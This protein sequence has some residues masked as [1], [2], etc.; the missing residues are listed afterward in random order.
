MKHGPASEVTV[1]DRLVWPDGALEALLA[2]GERRREL[3]AYFG[4]EEYAALVPVARRAAARAPD[5][6]RAV[7]LVPGIMGSQLGVPRAAPLPDDLLWIDPVD[8]SH[9]GLLRLGLQNGDVQSCGPVVHSYLRLKL[10]LS[11]EG[12]TVRCFDYDWRHGVLD[13]GRRL[14]AVL[15]ALPGERWHLVCHS[16]GGLVARAA[17]VHADARIDRIVTIGTPHAGAY[18]P[19]QALRGVYGTV[20]KLAQLDPDH[21]AEDLA[22]RVFGGF[23][24]LYDMLPRDATPDWLDA[25]SW[26]EAGPRP[27]AAELERTAR[28]ELPDDPARLTCIA[29]YAQR[30]VAA[31]R[32]EDGELR[33]VLDGHGDGTVPLASAAL[34]GHASRF[35][36]LGHSDLPR[37][38]EVAMAVA[39]LLDTGSTARLEPAPGAVARM[40]ERIEVTDT[41]LRT[42]YTRKLDWHS[43]T[44]EERRAWLDSLN[45]PAELP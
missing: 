45:A 18:A 34:P 16:M 4:A 37:S 1:Y 21:T 33:Y 13:L 8:F 27:H 28:L 42:L 35:A 36:A 41:A 43:I 22:T 38:R 3:I 32:R 30:T 12:F 40:P 44:A 23:P 39:D 9:G 5:P 29:G 6:R 14:A 2:S 19:M 31:A 26:P 15:A 7:V 10:A 17:L 25:A 24:S 20:R 11:A